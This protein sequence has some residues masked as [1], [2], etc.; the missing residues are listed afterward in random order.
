MAE[1]RAYAVGT[2]GHIY[3]FKALVCE[4]DQQAIERA[5]AAFETCTI[6]VWS[7]GRFVFKQD[8]RDRF[9]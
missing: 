4:D 6:E 7:G 1:Y 2:D 8:F 3:S 9:R 5:K